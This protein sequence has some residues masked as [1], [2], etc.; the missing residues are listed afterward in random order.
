MRI[1]IFC[2]NVHFSTAFQFSIHFELKPKKKI[3]KKKEL[4]CKC[5][6]KV[7][8]WFSSN[9]FDG[10]FFFFF[11]LWLYVFVCYTAFLFIPLQYST[12]IKNTHTQTYTH[13]RNP[14]Q[15]WYVFSAVYLCM[16]FNGLFVFTDTCYNQMDDCIGRRRHVYVWKCVRASGHIQIKQYH[17]IRNGT[18]IVI[19]TNSWKNEIETVH[20]EKT[21]YF[22][23]FCTKLNR[24]YSI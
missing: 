12:F 22:R 24:C 23:T 8:A 10:I 21:E 13:A 14:I 3:E 11:G 18:L 19:S 20:N 15:S 5:D 1:Y 2:C 6:E 7:S 4:W 9:D 16:L 17:I